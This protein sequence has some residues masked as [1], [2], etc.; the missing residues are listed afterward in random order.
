MGAN[1]TAIYGKQAEICLALVAELDRAVV[2]SRRSA[3]QM[4]AAFYRRHRE[5]G[6]RDRRFFSNAVFSWFRWR[7]WLQ[8][9]SREHVAAAILLDAT[10]IPPQVEFMLENSAISRSGLNPLGPLSIN[11]KAAGLQDLLKC[12]P[13]DNARLVPGWFPGLL[14]T[15]DPDEAANHLE[16]CIG[17]FQARPPAWLRIRSDQD[18]ELRSFLA[19]MEIET[20]NH[21]FMEQAVYIKGSVNRDLTQMRGAEPQD[22]ASQCVGLCCNPRPGE[23]WWDAC[24]GAG[25]KSLHLADLMNDDGLILAT[26]IRPSILN[27]LSKRLNRNKYHCV[28]ISLLKGSAGLPAEAALQAGPAPGQY[29]DGVLVDAPCSGSGTWHRSPDARWRTDADQV[30][31]YALIQGNL[32]EQASARVK[33]GGRLVYSTCSLTALENNEQIKI[34]LEKHGDFKPD[35]VFNPLTHQQTGGQIWIW[36]WEW[37]CNGMFIAVMKKSK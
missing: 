24:A 27:Q 4:L 26:D 10:A 23:Q 21:P 28:R 8:T 30:R 3:D 37:N 36:P 32:L 22:L 6:S 12:G 19:E 25:G 34:F 29:F 13:L 17:A 18:R 15:P 31:N 1:H 5:Y 20:G 11:A 9:P 16:A 14:Y 35:P 33:P 7:G 2:E